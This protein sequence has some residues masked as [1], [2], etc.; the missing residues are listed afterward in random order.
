LTRHAQEQEQEQEQ[1]QPNLIPR[2]ETMK[3]KRLA[4]GCAAFTVSTG[5][6]GQSLPPVQTRNASLANAQAKIA[7]KL[8]RTQSGD[9]EAIASGHW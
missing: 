5:V 2:G 8:T 1:E 9:G 6:Y 4:N 3:M 7:R